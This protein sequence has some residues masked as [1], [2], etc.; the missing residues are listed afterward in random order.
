MPGIQLTDSTSTVILYQIENE[1]ADTGSGEVRLYMQNLYDTARSGGITVP[2]FHSDK[3]RQRHL[4]SR[5]F[6]RPRHGYRAE[7][8]VRVR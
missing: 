5:Q 7:R 1:L 6:G 3:G 4:G 2:I 8:P